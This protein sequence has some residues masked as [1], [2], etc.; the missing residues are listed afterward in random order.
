MAEQAELNL[1]LGRVE[2]VKEKLIK[3]MPTLPRPHNTSTLALYMGLWQ[4]R[5]ITLKALWMLRSEGKVKHEVMRGWSWVH[6]AAEQ[7]ARRELEEL[8]R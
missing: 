5:D 7:K 8:N 2:K 6:S 3:L 4:G 1:E